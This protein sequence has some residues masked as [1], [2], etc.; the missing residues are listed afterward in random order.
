[1][2]FTQFELSQLVSLLQMFV[3]HSFAELAEGEITLHLGVFEHSLTLNSSHSPFTH[4]LLF[5]TQPAFSP[6]LDTQSLNEYFTH[7]S[8]EQ[9]SSEESHSQP[10]AASQLADVFPEQGSAP[11]CP[12]TTVHFPELTLSQSAILTS[13]QVPV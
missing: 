13:S 12:L 7:S 2:T 11:H 5:T 8:T 3:Q 9:I 10:S 6:S 1:L 4:L